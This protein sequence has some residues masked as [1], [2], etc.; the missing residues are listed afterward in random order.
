MNPPFLNGQAPVVP[1]AVTGGRDAMRKG[2]PLIWPVTVTVR[3]LPPVETA[4]LTVDARDV[5]IGQVRT[6]I[7]ESL[8][9]RA[10]AGQIP[11]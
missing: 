11:Q 2:S 10:I 1:I 3:I 5:L 9:S 6:A 7:A 8:G 4:G